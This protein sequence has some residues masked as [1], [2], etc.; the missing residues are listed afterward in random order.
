MIMFQ[1]HGKWIFKLWFIKGS[2]IIWCT[3][4]QNYANDVKKFDVMNIWRFLCRKIGSFG[5]SFQSYYPL[6]LIIHKNLYLRHKDAQRFDTSHLKRK[7]KLKLLNS[8]YSGLN[9]KVKSLIEYIFSVKN[10]WLMNSPQVFQTPW[11]LAFTGIYRCKAL[12]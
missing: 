2:F 11:S 6:W 8:S 1:I 3:I 9:W 5:R 4:K 10:L 12:I 7:I